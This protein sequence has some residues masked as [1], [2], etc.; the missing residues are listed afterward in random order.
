ME[1]RVRTPLPLARAVATWCF[2]A[3][4]L[5][6]GT[7]ATASPP[8]STGHV[9]AHPSILLVTVDTMRADHLQVYGY[10]R[11]TA[12][13]LTSLAKDATVWTH[14]YSTSSWTVP[15]VTSLLTGVYPASHGVVHGVMRGGHVFEQE[16]IPDDLP[17]LAEALK[18]AG[19]STFGVTANGHLDREHG[20]ARGFDHFTCIGI[21]TAGQVNAVVRSWASAIR[22]SPGP[23]FMWLHYFDPHYPYHWRQPWSSRFGSNPTP[24]ELQLIGEIMH[25]WPKAPPEIN[26]NRKRYLVV[27]KGLYDAEIRYWDTSF[28]QLLQQ[29]P[30]LATYL[31]VVSADHGEEFWDHGR[32]GHG[33][34]LFNETVRVPLIIRLPGG[35]PA[36][37]RAEPVSLLDLPPTLV[38]AAGGKIPSNWQG[39]SLWQSMVTGKPVPPRPLL[40]DLDRFEDKPRQLALI[41]SRFKF[42]FNDGTK[43]EKLFDLSSDFHEKR[44]LSGMDPQEARKMYTEL[45]DLV[46]SLPKPK[47]PPRA[48]AISAQ[49]EKQ[50]RSLGYLK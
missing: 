20:F 43:S 32:L 16:V 23:V 45:A 3:M 25:T 11:P 12:P 47:Q 30:E 48:A 42:I 2:G 13:Y 29:I 5:L 21:G 4:F 6:V 14:A 39:R 34:D 50:M 19:Y 49:R 26:R 38:E 1:Q 7:G 40:A 10:A 18:A 8:A 36:V 35:G 31:L 15:S 17:R 27:G 37:E 28:Q 46:R 9:S 22:S 33:V 44:N 24:H 41:T